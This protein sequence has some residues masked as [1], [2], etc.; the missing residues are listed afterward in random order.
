[1][2]KQEVLNY[3]LLAILLILVLTI[4]I[5]VSIEYLRKKVM[6][7]KMLNAELK[8][9]HQTDLLHTVIRSQEEERMRV[10]DALHDE[11][12]S[13]LTS[14][15]LGLH[16]LAHHP[17]SGLL[18]DILLMSEK[19][20]MR[21]RELSHEYSPLIVDKFGLKAGI[22]ELLNGIHASSGLQID[23]KVESEEKSLV[24]ETRLIL[25]R[26]TQELIN[27]TIKHAAAKKVSIKIN[28]NERMIDYR[29]QDDGKGVDIEAVS[30]GLG[31]LNIK[32]R[33][34]M[35][36]AELCMESEPGKGFKVII[37]KYF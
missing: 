24:K 9:K 30:C 15:K 32:N 2:E 3:I 37:T 6:K 19:V 10:S 31:M 29:F 12:G 14:I 23:L 34:A 21:T 8:L 36:D 11:V 5:I 28:V 25:Y 26:I 33:A 22:E 13:K 17:D 4:I 27:N 16:Q 1:M 18:N 7:E 35:M 20:V